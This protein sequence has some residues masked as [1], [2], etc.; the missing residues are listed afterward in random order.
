MPCAR[1]RITLAT[2]QL[3]TAKPPSAIKQRLAAC[4]E[5]DFPLHAV[6][7]AV[8]MGTI[9]VAGKTTALPTGWDQPLRENGTSIAVQLGELWGSGRQLDAVLIGGGGSALPAITNGILSQFAQ[10][11]IVPEG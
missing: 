7:L 8:R 6:D 4:F 11:E 9:N 1:S 5:V 2:F 10:T 3:G